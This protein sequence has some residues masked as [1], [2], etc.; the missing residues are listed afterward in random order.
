MVEKKSVYIHFI[1]H[2]CCYKYVFN[3]GHTHEC[4]KLI[5]RVAVIQF[6]DKFDEFLI[7]DCKKINYN[8]V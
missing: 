1:N 2:V 7:M 4:Y 3:K 5:K 6:L 8:L